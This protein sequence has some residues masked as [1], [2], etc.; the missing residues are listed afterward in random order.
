[1]PATGIT[2]SAT[3]TQQRL[4]RW[5]DESLDRFATLTTERLADEQPSRYAPGTWLVA[6]TVEG[7]FEKPSLNR[8]MQ[9][10]RDVQ[11][12]ETGWPPW[13]IPSRQ[14]WQPHPHEGTIQCWML[15]DP[16]KER[17]AAFSDYWRASPH[18]LMFLLRGYQE[19]NIQ[20]ASPGTILDF[21]IPLYR[22]GECLLHAERLAL[23]LAGDNPSVTIRFTWR[24]LRGRRLASITQRY[25]FFHGG[26]AQQDVVTSEAQIPA[27]RIGETLPEI[28][29]T[30]TTPLY[31]VFEFAEVSA[32]T[33]EQ[34][35][36]RLRN[37][38]W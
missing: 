15:E 30:L 35:I 19:D 25:P 6:Y 28:V 9:I 10:L 3:A 1:L 2:D 34:E 12:H 27:A 22:V 14:D 31:E 13:W 29:R 20:S 17:D 37:R 26:V 7:A 23:A 11:G 32:S 18:G 36:T 38:D 33:I 21:T 24:G 16:V 5:I 8:L 4:T